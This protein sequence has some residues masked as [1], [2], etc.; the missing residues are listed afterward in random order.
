MIIQFFCS[1]GDALFTCSL[2]DAPVRMG[3]FSQVLFGNT[4]DDGCKWSAIEESFAL[5]TCEIL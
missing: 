5:V 3:F 2:R 1:A 4:V